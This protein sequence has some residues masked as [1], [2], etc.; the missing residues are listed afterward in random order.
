MLTLP[1]PPSANKYWRTWK[2]RFLVSEEARVYKSAVKILARGYDP[3]SGNVSLVVHVFR[4]RRIGDLDNY[5]KVLMDSLR[6]VLYED[7]SQ[8]VVI[9]ATRHEDPKNPRVEVSC[10]SVQPGTPF[11]PT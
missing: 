7:D 4:P 11:I 2:G 1:I 5:L 9:Y 6:G 3:I 10:E 8:V